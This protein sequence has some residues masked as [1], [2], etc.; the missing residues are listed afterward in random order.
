MKD[1]MRGY[2]EIKLFILGPIQAIKIKVCLIGESDRPY[3]LAVLFDRD[4]W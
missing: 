4:C 3:A 2:H 1:I